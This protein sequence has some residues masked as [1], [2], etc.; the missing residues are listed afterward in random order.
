MHSAVH[1]YA[2]VVL[3][4]ACSSAFGKS[5]H[6]ILDLAEEA[7]RRLSYRGIKQAL[8]HLSIGKAVSAKM[9]VVHLKPD[10]TRTEY[11]TPS[12]L[13]GIVLVR[14]SRGTYR[15][16]PHKKLWEA[17]G[18]CP[19]YCD[20]ELSENLR[21]HYR[22]RLLGSQQIAGRGAYLIAAE[23]KRKGEP[24]HRFWI[25]KDSCVVVGAETKASDGK[26][27]RSYRFVSL[28]L[29]PKDIKPSV[30]DVHASVKRSGTADTRLGFKVMKPS[31]L[32]AGYKLVGA[33]TSRIN[34]FLCS[35][36]RF[37]NGVNTIS[38]FQRPA[39]NSSNHRAHLFRTTNVVTWTKDGM[40]FT[41]L[42]DISREELEKIARS[43][44]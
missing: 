15:Y 6:D 29:N 9:K 38:L 40:L 1:R 34:D 43:V 3:L 32:P 22:V 10:K 23:P 2:W 13:A 7:E 44:R 11:L 30:F 39:R 14:S 31:Y 12:A 17:M 26:L 35:H 8:V 27:L 37:S 16:D 21:H 5:V 19:V 42:G 20:D 36:L 33:G 41:L 18:R 25:D 4:L 28:E 24:S